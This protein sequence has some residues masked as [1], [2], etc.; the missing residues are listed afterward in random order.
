MSK[1]SFR[2]RSLPLIAGLLPAPQRMAL[3]YLA[4]AS[5]PWD[6]FVSVP[7]RLKASGQ[8]DDEWSMGAAA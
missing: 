1:E 7:Y 6:Y 2:K 4:D 3:S 8:Q 5:Q